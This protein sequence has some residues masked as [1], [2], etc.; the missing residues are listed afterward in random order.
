M[1]IFIKSFAGSK[2]LRR[3]F[4]FSVFHGAFDNHVEFL[5]RVAKLS[6]RLLVLRL[7]SCNDFPFNLQLLP[8]KKFVQV[9]LALSLRGCLGFCRI[10]YCRSFSVTKIFFFTMSRLQQTARSCSWFRF[11][12]WSC[13]ISFKRALYFSMAFMNLQ[14]INVSARNSRQHCIVISLYLSLTFLRELSSLHRMQNAFVLQWIN[15]CKFF[16]VTVVIQIVKLLIFR[17]NFV[18]NKVRHFE[19]ITI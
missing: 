1:R 15:E 4:L 14:N 5:W 2:S 12:C 19:S 10:F 16:V 9:K 13:W 8:A 11:M 17:V 3:K 7:V 6:D 18:E